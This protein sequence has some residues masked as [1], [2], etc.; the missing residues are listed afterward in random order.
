MTTTVVAPPLTPLDPR[1]L[2]WIL[3][4]NIPEDSPLRKELDS[5]GATVKYVGSLG[6]V[7][8]SDYT[9]LVVV[10]EPD[11]NFNLHN[12]LKVLQFGDTAFGDLAKYYNA[13]YNGGR[14]S[15]AEGNQAARFSVGDVARALGLEN[16][17]NQELLKN[18]PLGGQYR[19]IRRPT[20]AAKYYQSLAHETGGKSLAGVITN[21]AGAEWWIFAGEAS[22]Q[23]LWLRAA[24]AHWRAKFPDEFPAAGEGLGD[25]WLT[26]GE[27]E[28]AS[29][30]TAFE[31]ETEALL[32]E[33]ER[34]KAALTEAAEKASQEAE[35]NERRL[36]NAQGDELVAA[37]TDALERLGFKVSDSDA[38]AEANNTAKREDLQ[39]TLASR[40][41]WIALVEA[42][43]YSKGGA[44][45]GDLRQLAKAV[46]FFTNKSG[47]APDAQWYIVNAQFSKLPDDRPVPL[48]ANAEDVEDFSNDDGAII[49][50]RQ[51]FLL[52]KSV[53]SGAVTERQAQE[54]LLQARGI[55]V[56]PLG[57][58][59]EAS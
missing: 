34:A 55:Y 10:G 44:K 52:L 25:R 49:D 14:F 13:D 42:K 26:A 40:T 19:V 8:Q 6:E 51:I 16:L 24:L 20:A 31:A 4:Q 35:A 1:P 21:D 28:A 50:T 58:R 54:S 41:G 59:K 36:L 23:H 7:R 12:N 22:S 48:A 15:I 37:V 17:V 32:V 11:H 29:A 9:V 39:V 53:L 46:G 57:D 43:G 5:L 56:A 2:P 30:I 3:A 47:R 33:R 45:S 27:L 38:T 18:I